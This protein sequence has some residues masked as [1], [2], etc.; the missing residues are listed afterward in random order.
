MKK[1]IFIILLFAGVCQAQEKVLQGTLKVIG[2]VD[3]ATLTGADTLI[4]FQFKPSF[5]AE[6]GQP[7]GYSIQCILTD[8]V[9][10]SAIGVYLEASSMTTAADDFTVLADSLSF[11]YST[12]P[13]TKYFTGSDF[14]FPLG[15]LLINKNG[16]TEGSVKFVI[17]FP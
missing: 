15:G 17:W 11:A 9:E 6:P 12:Y 5:R 7:I 2:P 1:L 4:P 10:T 8:T 14:P 3:V 13:L 16:C